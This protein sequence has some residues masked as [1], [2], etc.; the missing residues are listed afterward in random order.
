MA[1]INEASERSDKRRI[2][3]NFWTMCFSLFV[4]EECKGS[5]LDPTLVSNYSQCHV[6]VLSLRGTAQKFKMEPENKF[7]EKEIPFGNHHFQVD[8]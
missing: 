1:S 4:R 2:C 3:L 6:R 5:K 7:G 8:C